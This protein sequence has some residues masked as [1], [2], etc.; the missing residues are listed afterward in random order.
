MKF[1]AY[2]VDI[3]A[4]L[5]LLKTLQT[6]I[7]DSMVFIPNKYCCVIFIS[8]LLW[9][10]CLPVSV[11]YEQGKLICSGIILKINVLFYSHS[12]LSII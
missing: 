10:T 5:G 6:F 3:C 12:M 7:F 11:N 8:L 9:K 4:R 2:F 1:I